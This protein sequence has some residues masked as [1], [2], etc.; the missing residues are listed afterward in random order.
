MDMTRTTKPTTTNADQRTPAPAE[1]AKAYVKCP[2]CGQ[3]FKGAR[4]LRSHQSVPFITSAC[5]PTQAPVVAAPRTM[6]KFRVSGKAMGIMEGSELTISPEKYNG[7]TP[8][9]V[10]AF[11]AL[12][13]SLRRRMGKGYSYTVTTTVAGAQV[14]AD[15][16]WTVSTAYLHGS[17]DPEVRDDGRALAR[18]EEAI[19]AALSAGLVGSPVPRVMRTPSAPAPAKVAKV[20]HL[21]V[22]Q[23]PA[24]QWVGCDTPATT[25]REL[26]GATWDVCRAHAT[27]TGR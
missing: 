22:A 8:G 3:S 24:C 7:G 6:V 9:A 10:D 27:G 17:S 12:K 23:A 18:V 16:C 2:G 4:G 14:I 21:T 20:R 26:A 19:R 15:Y 1:A 5:R 11:N 25:T 13:G